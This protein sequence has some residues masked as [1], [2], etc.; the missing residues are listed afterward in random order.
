MHGFETDIESLGG[1]RSRSLS[2]LAPDE[3]YINKVAADKLDAQ[4]G[5]TLQ[6]FVAGKPTTLTV[7]DI[8]KDAR[9][10]GRRPRRHARHGAWT[11]RRAQSSSTV[12][13]RRLHRRHER[14]RRPR[15]PAA[16][17]IAV[18]GEINDT[19]LKGDAVA[20]RRPRSRSSSTR[21]SEA[22]S[23][24]TTF[25]VILGLFSIA[26]GMLLIFLI[27]VMLAAERKV[28]MGMIRAVGTKRRHLIEMFLSEGMAYNMRRC[29][30]RL[31]ARRRS[32]RCVMVPRHG[33]A[34][35]AASI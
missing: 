4:K 1:R 10:D 18:T 31:R 20:G 26:A 22:A 32:S 21:A 25:F 30:R 7:K 33:G 24:L 6:I 27:F 19:E 23:F 14:R 13:R 28:E 8:V 9:A 35:R 17:P 2:D 15:Q 34:V 16:L 11:G 3:V 12:R 5:D 29:R